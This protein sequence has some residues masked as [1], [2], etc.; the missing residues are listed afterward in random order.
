M[1]VNSASLFFSKLQGELRSTNLE[2]LKVTVE[3][4]SQ[5]VTLAVS[6]HSDGHVTT[7]RP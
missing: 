5:E 7:Y 2:E 3:T 1:S 6:R 4:Y